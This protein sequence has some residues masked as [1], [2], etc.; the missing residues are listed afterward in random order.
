MHDSLDDLMDQIRGEEST[1]A[2]SG[3][4]FCSRAFE[5]LYRWK[6]DQPILFKLM[7]KERFAALIV[8]LLLG[9]ALGLV[10][11]MRVKCG[12]W[13]FVKG[14]SLGRMGIYGLSTGS[15][16]VQG[17]QGD[18]TENGDTAYSTR[19]CSGTHTH[20]QT[21]PRTSSPRPTAAINSRQNV[22]PIVFTLCL[23]IRSGFSAAVCGTLPDYSQF[24]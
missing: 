17:W 21:E 22:I 12:R 2:S 5:P 18:N 23:S 9:L 24:Y 7:L 13:L 14:G 3:G 4:G 10:Q 6:R 16:T 8:V 1:A 20:R 15:G 11:V 19:R